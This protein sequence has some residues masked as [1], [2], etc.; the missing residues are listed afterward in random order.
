MRIDK[1]IWAV[2]LAKTRSIAAKRCT[3]GLVTLNDQLSKPSKII[4]EGDE[5]A[6]R[7]NPIWKTYKVIGIPKSRVGA[8]L[9]ADLII[10]T[11]PESDL[12]QLE[13]IEKVN[14]YNKVLGIKGRP[15]KR[16][17]RDLDEFW[18]D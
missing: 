8:K 12:K 4:M 2:R 6:I 17:R 1:F 16:D 15:T 18:N 10:E 11:T 5:I 3:N 13:S 14:R 9:V 7:V